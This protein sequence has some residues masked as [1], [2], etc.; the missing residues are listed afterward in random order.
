MHGHRVPHADDVADG[1]PVRR[2]VAAEADVG[3][4]LGVLAEGAHG[5]ERLVREPR[6]A[7][8]RGV[9]GRHG[10]PAAAHRPVEL[11]AGGR[12]S[13][14]C[15]PDGDDSPVV[16]G[17]GLGVV[18][19]DVGPESADVDGALVH[20]DGG[21]AS[22]GG[23]VG[24]AAVHAGAEVVEVA[25]VRH[26]N[27][28]SVREGE[29]AGAAVPSVLVPDVAVGA[30][31]ALLARAT[32]PV[33][34]RREQEA[35]LD[36]DDVVGLPHGLGVEQVAAQRLDRV[37]DPARS[38]IAL[39]HA[40]KLL[41]EDV[42]GAKHAGAGRGCLAAAGAA[43]VGDGYRDAAALWRREHEAVAVPR[44]EAAAR[45]LVQVPNLGADASQ[46]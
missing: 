4:V 2:E 22:A 38:S 15:A 25:F 12:V 46:C 8:S 37:L 16:L 42:G 28:H 45:A 41:A 11:G 43:A 27:G 36:P 17:P 32:G 9:H 44:L 1:S 13:A 33:V 29:V 5:G 31:A 7:V 3:L 21:A 10:A 20:W 35:K 19:H 30:G 24:G 18:D 6:T 23:G 39:V 34:G 40:V 14:G 26:E